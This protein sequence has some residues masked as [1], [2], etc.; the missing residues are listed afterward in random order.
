MQQNRLRHHQE[1]FNGV[2]KEKK[3]NGQEERKWRKESNSI[4]DKIEKR[5]KKEGGDGPIVFTIAFNH[6]SSY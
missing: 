5:A 6:L 4:A 3:L 2:W 1:P